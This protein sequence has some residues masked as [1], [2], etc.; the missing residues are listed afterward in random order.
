M[1]LVIKFPLLLM[2]GSI[3]PYNPYPYSPYPYSPYP[4]NQD[5]YNPDRYNQEPYYPQQHYPTTQFMDSPQ[6]SSDDWWYS[7]GDDWEVSN[8]LKSISPHYAS[9]DRMQQ[10]MAMYAPAL[11]VGTINREEMKPP[12]P[13]Q[14]V[15]RQTGPLVE[16]WGVLE[17]WID[18]LDFTSTSD[19]TFHGMTVF[20]GIDGVETHTGDIQLLDESDSVLASAS[21]SITT[22]GS[23]KYF[24]VLF[25]KPFDIRAG[26]LYTL[27]VEYL[28]EVTGVYYMGEAQES[29]EVRCRE[30]VAVLDFSDSDY[31]DDGGTTA[32]EGLIPRF[33]ISC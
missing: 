15:S 7:M 32:D 8:T 2:F 11:H 16:D 24:D 30:G 14:I 10:Q 9:F 33:I 21:F 31:G 22:D 4:Y 19:M 17:D 12:K 29:I 18:A 3:N 20:G 5:P 13:I 23:P 1:N 26:V 27:S 25:D 28:D 6:V